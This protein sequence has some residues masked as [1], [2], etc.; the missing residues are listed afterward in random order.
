MP[1]DTLSYLRD[2]LYKLI[3]A[4]IPF[5]DDKSVCVGF[6]LP[7]SLSLYKHSAQS[8]Q[9]LTQPA[10]CEQICLMSSRQ[11]IAQLCDM[12]INR[13]AS[14][15]DTSPLSLGFF[16]DRHSP[17]PRTLILLDWLLPRLFHWV[18]LYAVQ[19]RSDGEVEKETDLDLGS[20]L[21]GCSQLFA[22]FFVTPSRSIVFWTYLPI[23]SPAAGHQRMSEVLVTRSLLV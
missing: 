7:L 12:Q 22:S 16:L 18:I 3:V 10:R 8:C 2:I 5:V 20:R 6:S 21:F 17:K 9:V 13:P 23:K 14:R 19:G 15:G 11:E 1:A 4:N